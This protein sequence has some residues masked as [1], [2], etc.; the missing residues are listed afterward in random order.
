MRDISAPLKPIKERKALVVD[1][2]DTA[3]GI[4]ENLL[5]AM[6]FSVT[7]VTNGYDA[8]ELLNTDQFNMVFADWNMPGING[9][10]L[11]K[12][13]PRDERFTDLKRFLVT[14]YGREVGIDEEASP[15]IDGFI[16]KPV[17][18]S[19]LLDAI[20]DAYGIEAKNLV[21]RNR[22]KIETPDL[23]GKRILLVEDNEI[24]QEVAI[25]LLEKTRCEV[26]I[27][28]NGKIALDALAKEH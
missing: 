25:G 17:N 23:S 8:I 6:E 22:A 26:T 27:A 2:N 11:L 4:M 1:D 9:V 18:P 5:E 7:S 21:K 16:L 3:R 20:M 28:G 24:N 14:A 10:E 19:T 12:R 15:L 13:L